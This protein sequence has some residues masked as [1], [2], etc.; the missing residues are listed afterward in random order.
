MNKRTKIVCTLGPACETPEMLEKMI[1]AGMNVARLNFSHGSYENHKMLFDNVKKAAEKMNEPVAILQDLQGPKI[2]VGVLPKEGVDLIVGAEVVFD[3]SLVDY[4]GADIPV[5]YHELH[6]FLKSGE[7]ILL[8]DGKMETKV[9]DVI[10]TKIKTVVVAGGKLTSHKGINVPDSTLEVRA[11]SEKDKEDAAFGVTLGVDFIALSFVCNAQDI[12]DLKNLI[13]QTEKEK[14]IVRSYPIKIIAKIERREALENIESILE[15]VD[16]IMV[17]RGDLGLEIPG[18]KVPV[19]QKQLI[20]YAIAHA[21]PVIVATQML[22]S[23]QE[24]P[25]P[26]RAEVSDVFNAVVDHTDAVMLS[27]E[28]AV[29]KFPVETV[30]TMSRIVIEAERSEFD[31][32]PIEIHAQKGEKMNEVMEYLARI[33]SEE[34][35]AGAIILPSI[36][37]ESAHIMSSFRPELPIVVAAIDSRVQ[38]Q[39][40]LSWGV[41]PFLSSK[42]TLEEVFSDAKIFL[43]EKNMDLK[44]YSAVLVG[45]EPFGLAEGIDSLEVKVF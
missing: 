26:T 15:V 29:G 9:L 22:D 45:G 17:A 6:R 25:R 43:Q 32:L 35:H 5:D 14:N 37:G 7:R 19:A 30:A 39:L 4:S 28:S 36:D 8:N 40:N 11:M 23:M 42:N 1:A 31:N 10:G 21:K 27:N 13:A 34:I 3:T 18:E 24:S 38:R 16:G 2:R 12:L 44:G 33:L 41:Y 20:R